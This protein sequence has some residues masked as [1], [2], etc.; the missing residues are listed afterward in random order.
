M[1]IKKLPPGEAIGARDLHEWSTNRRGGRSG[2]AKKREPETK[3][4]ADRWLDKR[5]Y[6][7]TGEVVRPEIWW[8]KK[9]ERWV[10]R[11]PKHKALGPKRKAGINSRALGTNP[12]AKG[13]NPRANT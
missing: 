11:Y 6:A 13:K 10:K 9:Q 3:D 8:S 2:V 1:E 4:R 5:P 12:R 7:Q